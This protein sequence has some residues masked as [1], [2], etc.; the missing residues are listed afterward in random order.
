MSSF[1]LQFLNHKLLD[2]RF[3]L[4][5]GLAG[6]LEAFYFRLGIVKGQDDLIGVACEHSFGKLI[7][8][9]V[10]I[11]NLLIQFTCVGFVANKLW[12]GQFEG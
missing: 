5:N 11:V 6:E 8:E 10:L 1:L 9:D 2:S 7:V 12:I 4:R 3:I